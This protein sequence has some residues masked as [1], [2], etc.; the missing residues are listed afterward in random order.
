MEPWTSILKWLFQLDDS[1][2]LH[3]KWV[4]HQTTILK[5]MFRVPG[6]YTPPKSN[7][8]PENDGKRKMILLLQGCIL[9]FQPLIFRGVYG[10]FAY[11]YHRIHT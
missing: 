8:E 11:I 6:M 2:S 10:I 1:K 7:I 9:R 4:L 5:W 3:E